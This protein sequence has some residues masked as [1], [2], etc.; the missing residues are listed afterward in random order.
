MSMYSGKIPV[1][2]AHHHTQRHTSLPLFLSP[3]NTSTSSLE[4]H[5]T[6]FCALHKHSETFTVA[7]PHYF[8]VQKLVLFLATHLL[9][10]WAITQETLTLETTAEE[11]HGY[12]IFLLVCLRRFF[13]E[14]NF[15][16][17]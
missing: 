4:I 14:N 16:Y 5:S 10:G 9:D 8:Q 13:I 6:H 2:L 1:S 11:H 7:M 17:M 15:I 3:A 12:L